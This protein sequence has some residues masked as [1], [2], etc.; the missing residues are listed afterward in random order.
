[1]RTLKLCVLFSLIVSVCQGCIK[2]NYYPQ[3]AQIYYT[4]KVRISPGLSTSGLYV[5]A[6]ANVGGGI[7]I[8]PNFNFRALEEIRLGSGIGKQISLLKGETLDL[9][10][11]LIPSFFVNLINYKGEQ[12]IFRPYLKG[13]ELSPDLQF[14]LHTEFFELFLGVRSVLIPYAKVSWIDH[15]SGEEIE[16]T[17]TG[18]LQIFLPSVCGGLSLGFRN[19]YLN[20]GI[21]WFFLGK[22]EVLDREKDVSF[23]FKDKV[24]FKDR[25]KALDKT[26]NIGLTVGIF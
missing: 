25:M 5:T 16:E 15:Y 10:F 18:L 22:G 24:G 12:D 19:V 14:S 11:S 21:V 3:P 4:E 1:M 6:S 2:Y 8:I 26:I 23:G 20:G 17:H 7:I 13:V 9:S